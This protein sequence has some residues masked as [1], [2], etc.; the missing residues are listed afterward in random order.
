[1]GASPKLCSLLRTLPPSDHDLCPRNRGHE[2]VYYE[3]RRSAST[4]GEPKVEFQYELCEQQFQLHRSEEPSWTSVTTGPKIHVGTV[5]A[6]EVV[7]VSISGIFTKFVVS[8]PVEFIRIR[9][10]FGIK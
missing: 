5:D 6:G 4:W 2:F 9:C 1:M 8:Q 3:E 10:H 7:F